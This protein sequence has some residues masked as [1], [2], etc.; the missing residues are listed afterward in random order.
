MSVTTGFGWLSLT[1]DLSRVPG[2]QVLLL[3]RWGFWVMTYPQVQ[4]L[5]ISI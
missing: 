1:V 4:L 2:R 5:K 3:I